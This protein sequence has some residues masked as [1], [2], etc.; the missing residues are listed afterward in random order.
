MRYILHLNCF[1]SVVVISYKITHVTPVS[2]TTLQE[3]Q[4]IRTNA[5]VYKVSDIENVNEKTRFLR[6]SEK[7]DQNNIFKNILADT[8]I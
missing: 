7:C 8:V 1:N 4:R 2:I 6:V 3:H 5:T